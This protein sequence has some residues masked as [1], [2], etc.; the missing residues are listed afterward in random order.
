MSEALCS[1]VQSK[2]YCVTGHRGTERKLAGFLCYRTWH[3]FVSLSVSNGNCETNSA[4][5]PVNHHN[6]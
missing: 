6:K 1:L 2:K 4:F 5:N 3:Y